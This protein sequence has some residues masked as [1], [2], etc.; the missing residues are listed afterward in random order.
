MKLPSR[1][2]LTWHR[3]AFRTLTSMFQIYN[4][5]VRLFEVKE[6]LCS[7]WLQI[8]RGCWW[9]EFVNNSLKTSAV[10]MGRSQWCRTTSPSTQALLCSNCFCEIGMES[11]TD[12]TVPQN[13]FTMLGKMTQ[14]AL[15]GKQ[16]GNADTFINP[17]LR[18]NSGKTS[19]PPLSTSCQFLSPRLWTMY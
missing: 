5:S 9:H 16:T 10:T 13:K 18:D 11:K 15:A 7:G 1:P 4:T 14:S 12:F 6:E 3:S 2:I 8:L 19:P 17:S